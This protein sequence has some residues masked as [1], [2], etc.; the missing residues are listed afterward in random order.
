MLTHHQLHQRHAATGQLGRFL[1]GVVLAQADN[2][3]VL[4]GVG[5]TA[6]EP[7]LFF[8][9]GNTGR[10]A[11]FAL[12]VVVSGHLQGDFQQHGLYAI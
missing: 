10:L 4:L 3:L 11:L 1:K 7:P 2:Q 9:F 6:F 12:L 5:L 8:R